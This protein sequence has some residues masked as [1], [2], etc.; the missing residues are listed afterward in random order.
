MICWTCTFLVGKFFPP[1]QAAIGAYVFIFFAAVCTVAFLYII[2]FIPETK[3]KDFIEIE[4]YFAKLNGVRSPL[5]D[6]DEL[7]KLDSRGE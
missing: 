5:L 4:D 1:I 2:K 6:A 3:G 7:K